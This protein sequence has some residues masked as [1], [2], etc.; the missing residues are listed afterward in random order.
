MAYSR[1]HYRQIPI[2]RL[3]V[4]VAGLIY[5]VT[6]VDLIPDPIPVAG[7]VDDAAVI[8]WVIK[9]LSDELDAFREWEVG[10]T[11]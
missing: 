9:S 11:D 6:P 8:A 7:Y 5:V 4:V 10:M 2:D 3:I 1:G